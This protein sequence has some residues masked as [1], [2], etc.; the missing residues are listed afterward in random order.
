VNRSL[1]FEDSGRATQSCITA[2]NMHQGGTSGT[3]VRHHVL[4]WSP[5]HSCSLATYHGL[6]P[7]R[8]QR[9]VFAGFPTRPEVVHI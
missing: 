5:G 8:S 3:D 6:S 7:K 9:K 2:G 1:P 4:S